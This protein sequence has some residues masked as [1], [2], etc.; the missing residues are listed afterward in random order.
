MQSSGRRQLF[1]PFNP[2]VGDE[3]ACTNRDNPL[4]EEGELLLPLSQNLFHLAGSRIKKPFR[5]KAPS[6][7]LL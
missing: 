7:Y 4:V 3:L 5:S 1:S 6:A 2:L